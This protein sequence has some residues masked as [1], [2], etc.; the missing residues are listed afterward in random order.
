MVLEGFLS[1]AA[2]RLEGLV[3]QAFSVMIVALTGDYFIYCFYRVTY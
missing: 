1:D 3:K 2:S